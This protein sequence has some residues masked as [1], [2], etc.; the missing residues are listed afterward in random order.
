MCDLTH[1][2][3]VSTPGKT[4]SKTGESLAGSVDSGMENMNQ[5]LLY[6][7]ANNL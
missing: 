6:I 4:G 3:S 2:A 5:H 1:G 7:D